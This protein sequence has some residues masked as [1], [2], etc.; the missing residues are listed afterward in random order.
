MWSRAQPEVLPRKSSVEAPERCARGVFAGLGL[1]HGGGHAQ[2]G[3][4]PAAPMLPRLSRSASHSA[5]ASGFARCNIR[6]W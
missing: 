4:A 5:G 1:G 2:L 6:G 3:A